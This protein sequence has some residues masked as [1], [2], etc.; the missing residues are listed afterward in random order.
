MMRTMAIVATDIWK[1]RGKMTRAG[2]DGVKE[3][4]KRVYRQVENIA[5][6]LS[7]IGIEIKDRTGEIFDYGLPEKVV[8]TQPKS[9]I[10]KKLVIETVKPTIY[11]N[12]QIL[13]SGEVI[14]VTPE[15]SNSRQSDPA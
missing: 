6:C 8:A 1:L 14:I 15:E 9:G 12:G 13:Q 4:F 7:D 10:S 5:E 11:F 3:E 2:S